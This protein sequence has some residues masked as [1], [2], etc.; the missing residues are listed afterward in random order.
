MTNNNKII[1][2]KKNA[3]FFLCSSFFLYSV[4]IRYIIRL[5]YKKRC[6]KKEYIENDKKPIDNLV[7]KMKN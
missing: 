6:R 3:I 4:V 5:C 1:N 2:S 7:Q